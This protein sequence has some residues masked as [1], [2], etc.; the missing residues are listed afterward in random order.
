M[1][2]REAN[3]PPVPG[4]AARVRHLAACSFADLPF[5][6]HDL[7][8]RGCAAGFSGAELACGASL[9]RL[10]GELAVRRIPPEGNRYRLTPEAVQLDLQR[11]LA[12]CDRLR[13]ASGLNAAAEGADGAWPD[14]LAA[15]RVP[16]AELFFRFLREAAL[17]RIRLKPEQ[18]EWPPALLRRMRKAVFGGSGKPELP[19]AGGNSDLAPGTAQVPAFFLRAA[20]ELGIL[21]PV[22]REWNVQP[23]RLIRWLRLPLPAMEERLYR[24]WRELGI[25]SEPALR[26]AA[27]L[28]DK[29]PDCR[30]TGLEAVA[31]SRG[32]AEGAEGSAG[33]VI[34][35]VLEPLCLL[36]WANRRA[37]GCRLQ[38]PRP[39]GES[40]EPPAALNWF[41]QPDFEVI[42]VGG[43][44]YA[45][46]WELALFAEPP[47]RGVQGTWLLTELSWQ[48]ALALGRTAE[49]SLSVLERFSLNGV[50]EEV[51]RQL[52]EWSASWRA[53]QPQQPLPAAARSPRLMA[54][55]VPASSTD[56]FGG[57]PAE[58]VNQPVPGPDELFP[59]WREVPAVWHQE[60][61]SYHLST[62][63]KLVVCATRWKTFL[64]LKDGEK[65]AVVQPAE[66]REEEG[67]LIIQ[68][69]GRGGEGEWE[70]EWAL[71]AGSALQIL[72]PEVNV[73]WYDRKNF[74]DASQR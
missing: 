21:L 22:K 65:S 46:L 4:L 5:L 29:L 1:S 34:A 35:R 69:R 25:P 66:V 8:R 12:A 55:A 73:S 71:P 70:W 43:P 31:Y 60:C 13:E 26:H 53:R 32:A 23:E 7:E 37:D 38:L 11:H 39:A 57:D 50:P 14:S 2:L 27:L 56:R 44:G 54:A 15:E 16:A 67:C 33:G 19:A 41:V 18:Q 6:W 59:G 62:A 64:L 30:V 52:E 72:L 10:A 48:R 24:L 47:E 74:I 63:R 36:G 58:L 49:E 20:G 61:R 51:R 45:R 40:M 9:L 28:Y 17:A 68:G 3:E 42:P